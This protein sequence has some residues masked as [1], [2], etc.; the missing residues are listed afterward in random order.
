[1]RR[2]VGGLRAELLFCKRNV[3]RLL[4]STRGRAVQ[5]HKE[6]NLVPVSREVAR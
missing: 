2:D 4:S 1:M 3:P 6:F 5:S